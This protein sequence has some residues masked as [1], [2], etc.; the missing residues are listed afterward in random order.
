M[1]VEVPSAMR[2]MIEQMAKM[3]VLTDKS[4][5]KIKDVEKSG[6]KFSMSMCEGFQKMIAS[7]DSLANVLASSLGVELDKTKDKIEDIPDKINIKVK[8]DDQGGR[9]RKGAT[10]V[11]GLPGR[12][13]GVR[14]L[15]RRH[16]RHAAR[17]GSHR[18]GSAVKPAAA[19]AG[20]G[21]ARRRHHRHQRP[22][23]LLRHAGRS[24]AAR[25]QSQCGADRE[26]WPDESAA[27]GLVGA[28]RQSEG[29]SLCAIRD[30]AIRRDAVELCRVLRSRSSGFGATRRRDR[31]D[32]RSERGRARRDRSM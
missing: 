25:R 21:G 7:V 16:A 32:G 24:P 28:H 8:Y 31:R 18:A 27:S 12:D 23:E 3:G 5:K 10:T 30:R 1:G 6:I 20:A 4:G 11:P 17:E 26:T 13:E 2:P 14:G 19:A 22:G 15:R 9:S 29:V